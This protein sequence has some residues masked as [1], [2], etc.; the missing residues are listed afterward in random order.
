MC[1]GVSNDGEIKEN[2]KGISQLQKFRFP[3]KNNDFVSGILF[4]YQAVN[5]MLLGKGHFEIQHHTGIS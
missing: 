5:T 3:N 1:S 4:P 2:I